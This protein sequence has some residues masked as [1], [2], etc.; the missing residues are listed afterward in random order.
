[1]S[2]PSSQSLHL[3]VALLGVSAIHHTYTLPHAGLLGPRQRQLCWWE[4]YLQTAAVA[5]GRASREGGEILYLQEQI[6]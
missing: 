5:Q 3:S 1:M 6:K 2:L 4:L